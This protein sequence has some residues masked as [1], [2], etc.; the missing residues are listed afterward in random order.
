LRQGY[1]N[2]LTSLALLLP[3]WS[4][5]AIDPFDRKDW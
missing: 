2:G 1:I 3:L 4:Q 5:L